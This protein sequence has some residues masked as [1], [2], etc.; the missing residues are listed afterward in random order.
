ML[1][2][3]GR[4]GKLVFSECG[5]LVSYG[6]FNIGMSKVYLLH[7]RAVYALCPMDMH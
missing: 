4:F 3:I 6:C 2:W 7:L 1:A 5:S